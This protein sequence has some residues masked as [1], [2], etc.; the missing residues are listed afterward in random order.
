MS[1]RSSLVALGFR[2]TDY[3]FQGPEIGAAV[4]IVAV[5]NDEERLLAMST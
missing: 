3:P 4:G 1:R 5:G 2:F